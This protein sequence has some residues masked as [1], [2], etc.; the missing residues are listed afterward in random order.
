[1][2]ETCYSSEQNQ[3]LFDKYLS[4]RSRNRR[5]KLSA[6]VVRICGQ[7]A[8]NDIC[9]DRAKEVSAAPFELQAERDELSASYF[10][11]SETTQLRVINLNTLPDDIYH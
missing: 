7:C 11:A 10:R 9:P 8:E 6:K 4:A 3:Q 2:S 1:M 5:E